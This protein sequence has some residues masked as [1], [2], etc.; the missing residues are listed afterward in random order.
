MSRHVAHGM[1]RNVAEH[2]W[3]R[4]LNAFDRWMVY[5]TARFGKSKKLLKYL[6]KYKLCRGF[7][8]QIAAAGYLGA[9]KHWGALFRNSDCTFAPNI[10]KVAAFHGRDEIIKYL[11]ALGYRSNRGTLAAAARGGQLGTFK[12]LYSRVRGLRNL[13]P[14]CVSNSPGCLDVLKFAHSKCQ[15]FNP[16][17][18]SEA[19]LCGNLPIAKY[20]RSLGVPFGFDAYMH[21]ARSGSLDLVQWLHS[22]GVN[23]DTKISLWASIQGQN[24]IL[25]WVFAQGIAVHKSC[26]NQAA[27][28]GHP[29][30]CKLL[31][32][33]GFKITDQVIASAIEGLG[34]AQEKIQILEWIWEQGVKFTAAPLQLSLREQKSVFKWL[35]FRAERPPKLYSLAKSAGREK[36]ARWIKKHETIQ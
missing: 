10:D 15:N 17:M 22:E 7:S 33:H 29:M 27:F 20:L 14:E 11:L 8:R 4:Y 32:S 34:S 18:L 16:S 35:Y 25:E 23:Y 2:I 9:L 1:H 26:L 21:A 36:I 5:A 31:T 13:T 30:T 28:Y 12:W 3:R 6:K 19:I 24:H